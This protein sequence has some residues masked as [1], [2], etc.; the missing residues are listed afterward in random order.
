MRGLRT[1][2]GD[3]GV[4]ILVAA[5]LAVAALLAPREAGASLHRSVGSAGEMLFGFCAG[6]HSLR[7]G[8]NRL[9]PSLAGLFGRRA[10]SVPGFP[11]S[12]A[13]KRSGIV[14]NEQTLDAWLADP[15]R[16]VPGTIM[17][18]QGLPDAKDR[19]AIIAFLKDA[20]RHDHY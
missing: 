8:E 17:P 15:R 16:F 12:Q 19:A 6:C 5:A 1:L 13:L 18:F 7:P 4:G 14:W 11:Y 9:A 3:R 10:G 2:L 20:T